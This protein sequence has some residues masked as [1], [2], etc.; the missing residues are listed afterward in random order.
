MPGS[1]AVDIAPN[2]NMPVPWGLPT[3][4]NLAATSSGATVLLQSD[5]TVIPRIKV[6]WDAVTDS[7]VLQGGYIEV[8]YWLAGDVGDNYQTAKFFP[9]DTVGYLTGVRSGG[10]YIVTA[11]TAS[12]ITQSTWCPLVVVNGGA[13]S[14]G[15]INVSGMAYTQGAGRVNFTWNS[16]TTDLDYKLTEVR[17][18][19]TWAGGSKV[20]APAGNAADW[21]PPAL[22]SYTAWF[23]HQNFSGIYSATPQSLAVTVD[24]SLNGNGSPAKGGNY[25]A[26]GTT[27]PHT[28][29]ANAGIKF[30]SDGT[31]Q[32]K[33]GGTGASYA[34]VG[35]WWSTT[36]GGSEQVQVDVVATSI[37]S[38]SPSLSGTVG[39]PVACSGSPSWVLAATN[40]FGKWSLAYQVMDGSGNVLAAGI[41]ILDAE[42]TD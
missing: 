33:Q 4:A 11:R 8:R 1:R 27:T 14:T 6:T 29:T 18:G 22:G 38:G 5:G 24:A 28:V 34:T 7:R 35:R 16:D 39:S 9:T 21:L 25:S 19:S 2:T 10:M 17:I 40:G 32:R 15:P 23:A 31:V 36:P 41:L 37:G 12:V 30:A 13:R 20:A 42:S 3:I 26:L